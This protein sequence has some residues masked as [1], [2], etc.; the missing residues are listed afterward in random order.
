MANTH[1][2]TKTAELAWMGIP[3]FLLL[4]F[5]FLVPL[6]ATLAKAFTD[7]EGHLSL[8]TLRTTFSQPY[9]LRVLGFTLRQALYSTLA[10]TAIGLPG[11]Y[12]LANYRFPGKKIVTA[13]ATV[14]F[15]LPSILVVLGFVIF[16]GNNGILNRALMA[17]FHTDEPPLRILYSLRAIILAH[18]FYNFPVIM[19][20]VSTYWEQ[21]DRHPEQAA[22]TLG[23]SRGTV[24][25]TITLPRLLPALFSASTLVFLFCYNS[26]AI[27]LVLGGGPAY[28]TMETEIYRKARMSLDGPGAAALALMSLIVTIT[29][30]VIYLA[31]QKRLKTQEE[32]THSV[33]QQQPTSPLGKTLIILYSV[34]TAVFVLG[35]IIS[36][37]ARSFTM[38]ASRSAPSQWSLVWYRQLFG[39][40]AGKDNMKSAWIALQNSLSIAVV[41]ALATI[42]ASLSLAAAAKGKGWLPSSLELL[43]MLPMA[44]SSVIIGL[45]Y[46]FIARHI[47]TK[48]YLLVVLAHL[49]IVIPFALRSVIPE[50][51]KIPIQY[52]AAARTLG[53]SRLYTFWT[54]EAPLLKNSLITGAMFA[55]ALSLGELNATLTLSDS[56]IVTLPI[57]MYQLIGSYNY[58]GACALG[59][60]LIIASLLVFLLTEGLKGNRHA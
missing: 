50:A 11:A 8:S 31:L 22:L 59:T 46:Y 41:V 48:G 44:V 30:L 27:I 55:F 5:L 51:R 36:V 28:T 14:P 19:N 7:G 54:I 35:P 13:V 6:C 49:V 33:V 43:G 17:L 15:V 1:G 42:P 12:L 38:T 2:K 21:M 37:V 16:Y 9:T 58:Q 40:I 18:A 57:V 60:I 25:R 24:F 52:V 29:L 26:F 39:I 45:G 23:A 34:L 53:A 32:Y 47:H 4:A 56:T 3:A 20:L 10:S